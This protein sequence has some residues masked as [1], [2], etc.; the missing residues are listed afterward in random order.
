[1]QVIK[2]N[3]KQ[4]VEMIFLFGLMGKGQYRYVHIFVKR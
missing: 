1:M 3:I 4:P 2:R